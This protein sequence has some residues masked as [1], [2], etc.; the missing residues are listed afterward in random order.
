MEKHSALQSTGS[1]IFK[2]N[3][4]TLDGEP[5]QRLQI[6]N[7]SSTNTHTN[8]PGVPQ[9]DDVHSTSSRNQCAQSSTG[10][11]AS[12]PTLEQPTNSSTSNKG[13]DK[14]SPHGDKGTQMPSQEIHTTTFSQSTQF[15][16]QQL[17][18]NTT[19]EDHKSKLSSTNAPDTASLDPS[20]RFGV[21]QGIV[22][23]QPIRNPT[24]DNK[25][26]DRFRFQ[27]DVT[28]SAQTITIQMGQN[29]T[30]VLNTN[31]FSHGTRPEHANSHLKTQ[32]RRQGHA[33]IGNST[34][35]DNSRSRRN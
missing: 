6:Q 29:P 20:T 31:D 1:S 30:P 9:H 26:V 35:E 33:S 27:Q 3:D 7:N 34:T 19:S 14:D 21:H 5:H 12:T 8:M 18:S 13:M 32:S 10:Q 28:I 4:Q 25:T 24:L 15:P 16:S 23:R 11:K 17:E 22:T 2:T